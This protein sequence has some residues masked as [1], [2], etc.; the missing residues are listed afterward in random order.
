MFR[1]VARRRSIKQVL[2]DKTGSGI[3]EGL[4]GIVILLFITAALAHGLGTDVKAVTTVAT[5][6]ERQAVL[7]DLVGNKHAGATWG[8]PEAPSTQTVELPNGRE[9]SVTAW[10]EVTPVSTRLT[11]VAPISSGP[12]AAD[13]T[14]PSDV[15]KTGCIY[16]SR[17]HAA[18]LD[19]IS[20]H[21]IVR[22]DAS[23][24]SAPV[25]SVDARVATTTP[26]PQSTTFATGSDDTATVWR[27]L[28]TARAVEGGGE[29]R[30]T[31]AGK[32]LALFPV[33]TE[34]G[35][36]FGTFSAEKNVPVTATVTQGDLVVST[37]FIYRAGS[38]S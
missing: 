4:G 34:D 38:T 35:N 31:Q 33:D 12:D 18:D 26:V 36:Y 2:E 6:A 22:K 24:A 23:T 32:T 20:P 8:T 28:V 14:G 19:A 5:K 3:A 37:V 11:A 10:R 27:Y 13:C 25:G 7:T 16:S 15:A 29:I 21:T 30:I 9:V 1:D 17:L